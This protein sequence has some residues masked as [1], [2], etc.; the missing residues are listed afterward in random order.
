MKSGTEPD[1]TLENPDMEEDPQLPVEDRV[2]GCEGS[3]SDG[4]VPETTHQE[5]PQE[6]PI[7]CGQDSDK[8]GTSLLRGG[9]DVTLL[10][11]RDTYT[12]ILRMRIIILSHNRCTSHCA[13][14]VM[15]RVVLAPLKMSDVKDVLVTS[16]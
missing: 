1:K 9:S 7:P 14:H 4:S 8:L 16:T 3:S 5:S 13:C 6:L 11:H 2:D 15:I 12:I 10:N